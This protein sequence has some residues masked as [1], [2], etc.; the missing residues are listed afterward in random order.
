MYICTIVQG[1]ILPVLIFLTLIYSWE[2]FSLA[3]T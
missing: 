3:D 2:I 1:D